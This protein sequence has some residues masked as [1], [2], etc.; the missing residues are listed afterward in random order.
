MEGGKKFANKTQGNVLGK[1]ALFNNA[2]RF[3]VSRSSREFHW[4]LWIQYGECYAY[5]SCW[6]GAAFL[7]DGL[8]WGGGFQ[9]DSRPFLRS[10]DATRAKRIFLFL[11]RNPDGNDFLHPGV[12]H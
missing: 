9:H 8:W 6:S 4:I 1:L 12:S 11:W 2:L 3:W 10:R 7:G 5:S